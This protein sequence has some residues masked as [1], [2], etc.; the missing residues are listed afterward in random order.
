MAS[1]TTAIVSDELSFWDKIKLRFEII[2]YRR[3]SIELARLGYHA[4]ANYCK[5]KIDELKESLS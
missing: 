5:L 4:E 1:M 2:G 3:A